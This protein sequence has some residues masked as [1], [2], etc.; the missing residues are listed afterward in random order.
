MTRALLLDLD[1]TL[2]VE[3][4]AAVAA[5]AATARVAAERHPLDAAALA[6]DARARARGIWRAAPHYRFCR[7]I[8]ISSWEGLFCRYEG[9]GHELRALREWAPGYR[10]D[11]WSRALA[12][13]GID[14]GE[15]A[16]ELGE[17]FGADRRALH[18]TFAD[19]APALDA[20]GAD[21]A[22]A[23]VTN[24][25][26]C[27]QRE[28]LMASGLA[29]RF[30]VVV[31]SGELGTAKPDPAVYARGLS[32]LGAEP[33]EAV[34]V[35]DSLRNDVDGALGAGLSAVWLNRDGRPR[36]LDRPDVVE[37]DTLGALPAA[38]AGLG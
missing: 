27:W 33:G 20:L 38:L 7:R 21:H 25:A 13:Q 24:G 5:F 11:A 17:R 1:D 16:A 31:V 14:D 23:L 30:A 22:L 32:E 19:A 26:S 29:D 3:E 4:P 34:M 6:L 8:G 18:E 28:K 2:I 10:R 15:L 37:I 36:P 9:D 12:D 35:G